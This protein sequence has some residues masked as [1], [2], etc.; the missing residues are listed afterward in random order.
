MRTWNRTY[1]L[2]FRSEMLTDEIMDQIETKTEV[3]KK[4]QRTTHQSKQLTTR[5]ALNQYNLQDNDTIDLSL[6]L[7][8]GTGT[9]TRDPTEQA[10]M[11]TEDREE[12]KPNRRALD[13]WVDIPESAVDSVVEKIK[14][15]MERSAKQ[16]HVSI[17]ATLRATLSTINTENNTRLTKV[18]AKIDGNTRQAEAT[19]TILEAMQTRID[20]LESNNSSSSGGHKRNDQNSIR[21]VVQRHRISPY[22]DQTCIPIPVARQIFFADARCVQVHFDAE[23]YSQ[24]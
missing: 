12:R 23:F 19:P 2:K 9:T 1:A 21:A 20:A 3:P 15:D 7:D 13:A 6:H 5:R 14:N 4:Q 16:N 17:A 10:A 8:G 11:D 22:M 24:L 18:E